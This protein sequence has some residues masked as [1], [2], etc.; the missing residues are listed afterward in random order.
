MK[1]KADVVIIGGGIIGASVAYQL[2]VAQAAKVDVLLLEQYTPASGTTGKSVA[3]LEFQ[4]ATRHAITL[5]QRSMAIY[6]RL[7]HDPDLGVRLQ[8][9]GGV[10]LATTPKAAQAQRKAMHLQQ[11]LGIAVDWLEPAQLK[12]WVPALQVE[13]LAGA[14]YCPDE[15]Y[16]DPYRLVMALLQE[17][18]RC[19]VTV[20]TGTTV[21]GIAVQRGRV[22][23][24][25]TNRGAIAARWVVDAA[26]PWAKRVAAMVGVEIPLAHTKCQI[27]PVRPHTPFPY[28]IPWVLD[29]QSGFYLREDAGGII[30]LG[31]LVHAFHADHLLDPDAYVGFSQQPDEEFAAFAARS[32]QQRVPP[33]TEG[34]VQR[35]WAGL[36]AVTPDTRPLVG[37]T[38]VEGFLLAAGFGG[39][40]IQLG[41]VAG[42]V[43]A[44]LI[45]GQKAS[46]ELDLWSLSRFTRG[47]CRL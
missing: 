39:Y 32:V 41:A 47:S 46:P 16:V 13:D 11:R 40:G 14:T 24:V 8:R 37:E 21:T 2:A 33:L 12:A 10:L 29:R 34:R 42:Q 27:L 35:G 26:G 31:R 23:S 7:F 28:T 15:G 1:T 22:H 30:L 6:Q 36:R 38:P 4:H 18:K 3:V 5:R 9:L 43:L 45:L 19:G 25:H 17:A 44:H 20:C